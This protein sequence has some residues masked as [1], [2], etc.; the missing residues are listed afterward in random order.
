MPAKNRAC[1]DAIKI[2][3]TPEVSFL[4]KDRTVVWI[5]HEN[6][7]TAYCFNQVKS[8]EDEMMFAKRIEPSFKQALYSLQESSDERTGTNETTSNSA[9][10]R[11]RTSRLRR[12]ASIG[13]RRVGARRLRA[14]SRSTATAGG[15]STAGTSTSWRTVE[16]DSGAVVGRDN[17]SAGAVCARLS[18][19][20]GLDTWADGGDRGRD[21]NRS[22]L[23]WDGCN[24]GGLV[25]LR[26]SGTGLAGDDAQRVGLGEEGGL[27][28]GVFRGLRDC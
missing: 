5:N 27:G 18:H 23:G 15:R 24:L 8:C 28:E 25:G 20:D 26:G 11:G 17:E 2:C 3:R 21:A 19:G 1:A 22:V 10:S 7:K 14:R 12:S 9:H 16:H 13:R 4:R 6:A